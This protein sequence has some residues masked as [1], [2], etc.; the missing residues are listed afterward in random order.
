MNKTAIYVVLPLGYKVGGGKSW[1][2]FIGFGDLPSEM[3][4]KKMAHFLSAMYLSA[5]LR[6]T[7]WYAAGSSCCLARAITKAFA[8]SPLSR[9]TRQ[10]YLK[11]AI[12]WPPVFTGGYFSYLFPFPT[13]SICPVNTQPYLYIYKPYVNT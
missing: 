13:L 12:Y 10:T 11:I 7:Y 5:C 6:S 8:Y 4:K 1:S 2:L 9:N 3:S